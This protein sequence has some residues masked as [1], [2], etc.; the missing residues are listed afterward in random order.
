VVISLKTI[1]LRVRIEPEFK[2]RLERAVNNGK[3]PNLSEL[4]RAALTEFLT[5]EG[6]NQK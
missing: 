5:K 3:A 1:T 6:E 2:Q 4:I